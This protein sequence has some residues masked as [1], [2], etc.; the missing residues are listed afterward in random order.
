MWQQFLRIPSLRYCGR[1]S[2]GLYVYHFLFLGTLHQAFD[3]GFLS[4][5]VHSRILGVALFII[6]AATLSFAAAM[7]S[8]HIYEK[9]FLKLKRFFE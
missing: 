8:W 6:V 2:Y 1:I 5:L 3:P 9:Q 7:I 4:E